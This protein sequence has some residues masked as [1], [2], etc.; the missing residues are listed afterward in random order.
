MT[1][2]RKHEIVLHLRS[3]TYMQEIE[4]LC[5]SPKT[6][7]LLTRV[8]DNAWVCGTVPRLMTTSLAQPG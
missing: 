7:L 5:V 4:Q 8:S 3:A 1:I 6:P 2:F